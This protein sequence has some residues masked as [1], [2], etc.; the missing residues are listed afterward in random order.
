MVAGLFAFHPLH[1]ESVAW[2]AERKDLLSGMFWILTLWEYVRYV[3]GGGKRAYLLLTLFFAL[4]LMSKPMVVTLP[5]VLLLLDFWPF[6]RADVEKAKRSTPVGWATLIREKIPL[7]ILSVA[8]SVGTL[9]LQ[10]RNGSIGSFEAL[11]LSYRLENAAVSYVLY[12][13]KMFWPSRLAALYPLRAEIPAAWWMFSVLLLVAITVAALKTKKSYPYFI[14][15]WLWYLGTMVPVI[16]LIQAG[17][18]SMADRFTYIPLIGLFIIVAWGVPDVLRRWGNFD[19]E[20]RVVAVAALIACAAIARNQAMYWKDSFALWTH[21]LEVT[22]DNHRAEN[23]IGNEYLSRSNFNEALIHYKKAIRIQ[24]NFAD[25]HSGLGSVFQSLNKMDSAV[26]EYSEALRLKP[27]LPEAHN[28]MGNLL[29]DAGDIQ[30][31]IQHFNAGL[32]AS[33]ESPDLHNGLGAAFAAAGRNDAALKEFL[34][35][36]RLR[37]DPDVEFN[38]GIIF[39]EKRNYAEATRHFEEAIHLNPGHQQAREQLALIQRGGISN[40]R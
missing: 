30:S 21:T 23:L 39:A 12:I 11:P 5:F 32:K 1:V 17:D 9:L 19:T 35:S 20:I 2:V 7:I 31:A 16:G 36:A 6:E 40:A 37:A 15:G 18:Q 8:V 24:P 26:A 33:P 29:V 22:R 28:N 38:I 25:A 34:E 10:P 4:G 27:D 3:K 14:V 13:A